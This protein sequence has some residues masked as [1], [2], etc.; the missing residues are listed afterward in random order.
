M[1]EDYEVKLMKSHVTYFHLPHLSCF[2][3]HHLNQSELDL[4][5]IDSYAQG[6]KYGRKKIQKG[7]V[8]IFFQ[9]NLQFAIVNLNSYCIGKDTE[10]C[11][12][13]LNSIVLNILCIGYLLISDRLI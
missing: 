2:S 1:S 8:S 9:S 12:L 11:A 13:Q 4:I 3:E 5:H 10:V 6:T 7:G